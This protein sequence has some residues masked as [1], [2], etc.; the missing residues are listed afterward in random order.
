MYT[1]MNSNAMLILYQDKITNTKSEYYE[2][3]TMKYNYGNE[4]SCT[5]S[6]GKANSDGVSDISIIAMLFPPEDIF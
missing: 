4:I 1:R 2:R 3:M 6:T 5:I